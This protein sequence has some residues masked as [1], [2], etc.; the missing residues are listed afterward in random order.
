MFRDESEAAVSGGDGGGSSGSRPRAP[1]RK[2]PLGRGGT[3]FVDGR[4]HIVGLADLSATGAYLI[5]RVHLRLG[6]EVRLVVLPGG[7]ELA[8]RARVVRVVQ[9]SEEKDHHPRGVAVHFVGL[10]A[11]ARARLE[12]FVKAGSAAGR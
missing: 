3:L 1:R 5:T 11:E 10:D 2:L 7:G 9:G 12:C 8:L 4:T 6:E